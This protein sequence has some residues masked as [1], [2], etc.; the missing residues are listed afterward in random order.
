M[1]SECDGEKGDY[2][3]TVVLREKRSNDN[4]I[5]YRIILNMKTL[6]KNYVEKTHHKWNP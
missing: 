2:I 3:N 1:I 6:N 4:E 5:K